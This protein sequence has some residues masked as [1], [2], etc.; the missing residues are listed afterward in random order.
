MEKVDADKNVKVSAKDKE[1]EQTSTTTKK[2]KKPKRRTKKKRDP[3]EKR[4]ANLKNSEADEEKEL[5]IKK[6]DEDDD[7]EENGQEVSVKEETES[8]N[9]E[10]L[11]ESDSKDVYV[12]MSAW[13]DL[14]VPFELLRAL[15]ELKFHH[16]MPI[17]A[18]VLP[19]AI[20]G[21]LDILGAAE[22]GS[23]KTLAFGIPLLAGI[24][25][26]IER[27]KDNGES[28][29]EENGDGDEE[30][31]ETPS[32]GEPDI[33][34]SSE[35]E[36]DMSDEEAESGCVKVIN[37]I[38]F[39]FEEDPNEF[40]APPL[41]I[42]DEIRQDAKLNKSGG[43]LRGLVLAPTRELAIQ[44]KDHIEA[45]AR[46]TGVRVAVVVGGMAPQ[47]QERLLKRRPEIVVA[48]PGRLWDLIR[49]GNE[50]LSAVKDIRYLVIDETDRMVEKGHFEELHHLLEMINEEKKEE[51]GEESS[52]Q[53]FV[54]SAT[55]SLVHETP[56]HMKKKKGGKKL[57][58]KDKLEEVGNWNFS[59]VAG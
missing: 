16:P 9:E 29:D 19:A 4:K 12:R 56:S 11:S 8:D 37:D 39:D 27:E 55:M 3:K 33:E 7:E 42:L 49:Q 54:F 44:V 13:N 34:E 45:A 41:E 31:E 6:E 48:T 14:F 50:H 38:V 25:S 10:E 43:K 30:Q 28:D 52:R 46:H 2:K 32:R 40:I 57:T 18:Q 51:E 15:D 24:L 1:V 47:K 59:R 21:R 53:N 26:D 17:Q 23:G 35:E 20:K 36:E 5:N 58:V 22:T